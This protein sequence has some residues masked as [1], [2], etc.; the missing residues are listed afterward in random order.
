MKSNYLILPFGEINLLK[1]FSSDKLK[2]QENII[3]IFGNL[4]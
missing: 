3:I 4:L 2:E 1:Y